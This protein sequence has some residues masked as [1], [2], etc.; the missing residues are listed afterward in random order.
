MLLVR[1]PGSFA[2]WPLQSHFFYHD[3]NILSNGVVA[4]FPLAAAFLWLMVV[5]SRI[6]RRRSPRRKQRLAWLLFLCAVAMQWSFSL[7][8]G[9]GP[10]RILA[11]LL[12]PHY[13]HSEFVVLASLESNPVAVARNYEQ[14][15]ET[16]RA[17]R[18]A[19]SK[20]PGQLVFYVLSYDLFLISGADAPLRWLAA[21]LG[22]FDRNSLTSF[23]VF[24]SLLF[25]FLSCS[26]ILVLYRTGR[27]VGDETLGLLAGLVFALLPSVNLVTM[28]MD[29]VLYP[30]LAAATLHF[31]V[32]A[33][34]RDQAFGLV[35]G[36]ITWL[37]IYVSFSLLFLVPA[38][39]LVWSAYGWLDVA[40][41]RRQAL[42]IAYYVAGLL[43][44]WGLFR[45]V[46]DYDPLVAYARAMNAHTGWRVTEGLTDVRGN[47]RNFVELTIWMG[48]PA[49]LMYVRRLAR[50][51]AEDWRSL[52][53]LD[54]LAF[55]YPALVLAV[56][57]FGQTTTE[58]GR[59]WIPLMVPMVI[60][61]ARELQALHGE[62]PYFYAGGAFTMVCL[63]KNYHDFQ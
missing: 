57:I 34:M 10:K 30:L 26:P 49:A 4:L 22:Y 20:P 17:Y 11:T 27:L 45:L 58:I 44:C 61:I 42:S 53:A 8:E 1:E 13:G 7:T 21:R 18:Y 47:V 60:P 33:A 41:R 51:I 5:V 62:R 50:G 15:S 31:A 12:D 14:A 32:L 6:P 29:Q 54:V 24:A 46:L 25:V 52:D 39:L 36:V 19:K 59:L 40:S 56:S 9:V 23:G 55:L 35:A 38:L 28:H 48:L 63:V 2:R 43:L 3:K 16:N 37:A